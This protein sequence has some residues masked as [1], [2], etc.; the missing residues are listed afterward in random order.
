[1]AARGQRLV[2][3]VDVLVEHQVVAGGRAV[4]HR[5][6]HFVHV[7]RDAHA[8][9]RHHHHRL[10]LVL[11]AAE[12]GR[13]QRRGG[14]ERRPEARAQVVLWRGHQRVPGCG[15]SEVMVYGSVLVCVNASPSAT[16]PPTSTTPPMVSVMARILL[17]R[18]RSASVG[19]GCA[20]HAGCWMTTV[21]ISG[22]GG[23]TGGGWCFLRS[24][25]WS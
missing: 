6:V 18:L 13:A 3:Q 7:G 23:A 24:I 10:G 20:T 2:A 21:R 25:S 22:G 4:L 15:P 17:R 9:R 11:G 8:G 14:E 1:E 16:A 5:E 19:P 12:R